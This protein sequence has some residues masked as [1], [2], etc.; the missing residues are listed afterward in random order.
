MVCD[1]DT[2]WGEIL[3]GIMLARISEREGGRYGRR[4]DCKVKNAYF[5]LMTYVV[6]VSLASLR[7]DS[8]KHHL[9]YRAVR[10]KR[11]QDALRHE[12]MRSCLTEV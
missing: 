6:S 9:S 4:G 8:L 10:P 1:G 2:V 12:S 5:K 3:Y 7:Q 11:A